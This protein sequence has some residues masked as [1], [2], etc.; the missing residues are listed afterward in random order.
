ME[1]NNNKLTYEERKREIALELFSEALAFTKIDNAINNSF[2]DLLGIIVDNVKNDPD[3][4][5]SSKSDINKIA[6]A[7]KKKNDKDETQGGDV[8]GGDIVGGDLQDVLDFIKE[9]GLS[10]I[11]KDEKDFFLE[12]IKLIFCGCD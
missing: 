4:T 5:G 11:L 12:I 6:N 2:K 3:F 9:L 7:L 1:K 10:G 8:T